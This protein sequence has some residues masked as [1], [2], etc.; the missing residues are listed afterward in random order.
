MDIEKFFSIEEIRKSWE[1]LDT[2]DSSQVDDEV[3]L[4]INRLKNIIYSNYNTEPLSII[5]DELE[6]LFKIRFSTDW[7][8]LDD[9]E[10]LETIE[11]IIE[12]L[13]NIEE[14]I[15]SYEINV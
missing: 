1:L 13:N 10:Q 15:D 4:L 14:L 8:K 7:N 5:L 11:K 12:L 2:K 6:K 9:K 3:S